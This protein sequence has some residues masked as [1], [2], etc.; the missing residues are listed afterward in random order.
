MRAI[1]EDLLD[2]EVR[3]TAEDLAHVPGVRIW[4]ED[5]DVLVAFAA[6]TDGSTGLFRL[7]CARFDADPPSVA[8]LDPETR[9]EFPHERWAPGVSSGANPATQ[10]PFVCL[11]GVAEYHSHPSHTSDAWD[12]YRYRFRLPQTVR[13]LLQKAGALP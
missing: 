3:L 9:E 1:T 13:R 5:T 10:R 6:G 12:K 8:M 2:E 7:G 4:R 11:Q